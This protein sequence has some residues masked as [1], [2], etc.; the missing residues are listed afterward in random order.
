MKVKIWSLGIVLL[1]CTLL[2]CAKDS[3]YEETAA[4]YTNVNAVLG[5]RFDVPSSFLQQTTAITSLSDGTILEREYAYMYKDGWENYQLF[6][7]TSLVIAAKRGTT[8]RFD[9]SDS[10]ST[11]LTGNGLGNIWFNPEG[12]KMSYEE[13][14]D[15]KVYKLITT[16]VAEVSITN[17]LYGNFVGKLAVIDY[18]DTEWSLFIGAAGD[19]YEDLSSQQKRIIEH[20]VKSMTLSNDADMYLDSNIE[21]IDILSISVDDNES[22]EI[23]GDQ[24]TGNV[25]EESVEGENADSFYG[26]NIVGQEA[27]INYIDRNGVLSQASVIVDAVHVGEDANKFLQEQY[28]LGN[29]YREDLTAPDGTS[30]HVAEYRLGVNP[31]EAYIDISMTGTNRNKL[32]HRGYYYSLRSF[33]V[34]T[35]HELSEDGYYGKMY[36]FYAVP[37]GCEEYGLCIGNY[38]GGEE[39]P[40]NAYYY[41]SLIQEEK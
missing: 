20:V 22:L 16:V 34:K 29:I 5:S 33:E 19:S 41:I 28:E 27:T 37:D 23:T 36:R 6:Q 38:M 8:F 11:A 14:K 30:W 31:L 13:S 24:I 7:M 39:K 2:G 17:N 12:K 21:N 25:V 10:K 9:Q 18:Q 3:V 40:Y 32:R 1:A 4:G 15:D 26:M 35:D